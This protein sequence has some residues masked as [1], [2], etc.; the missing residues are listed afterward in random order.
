MI[1]SSSMALSHRMVNGV[2]RR[3]PVVRPW[4][5]RVPPR[6]LARLEC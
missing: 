3:A 4:T 6:R 2:A 1:L 5:S